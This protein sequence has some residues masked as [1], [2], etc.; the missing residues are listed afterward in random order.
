MPTGSFVSCRIRLA[1]AASG[2]GHAERP[3]EGAPGVR[4]IGVKAPRH[5]RQHAGM[6]ECSASQF[7]R[8]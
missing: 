4:G 3:E 1:R 8:R 7:A 2:P 6:I 5:K